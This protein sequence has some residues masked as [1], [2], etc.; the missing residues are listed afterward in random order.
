MF[1]PCFILVYHVTM[2]LLWNYEEKAV[3]DNYIWVSFHCC[4]LFLHICNVIFCSAH[5]FPLSNYHSETAFSTLPSLCIFWNVHV[6]AAHLYLAHSCISIFYVLLHCCSF[7]SVRNKG[8]YLL[9]QWSSSFVCV[10]CD[11]LISPEIF[12]LH[13]RTERFQTYFGLYKAQK[14]ICFQVTFSFNVFSFKFK[15]CRC[16]KIPTYIYSWWKCN[17]LKSKHNFP[18]IKQT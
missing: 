5:L 8:E 14:K 11:L 2:F 3:C 15:I 1:L 13:W 18:W 16:T 7:A 10:S 9:S 6:A 17:W 4:I 12:L